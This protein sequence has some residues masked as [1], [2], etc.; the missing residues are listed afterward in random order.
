M[1]FGVTNQIIQFGFEPEILKLK[2][3]QNE[4]FCGVESICEVKGT[5]RLGLCKPKKRILF[6]LLE[7]KK[8]S[9]FQLSTC[10]G[11]KIKGLGRS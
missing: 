10:K 9:E 3:E 5:G 6:E 4:F 7:L 2:Q 1:R 8:E 11:K